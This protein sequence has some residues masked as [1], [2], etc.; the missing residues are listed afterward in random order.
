MVIAAVMKVAAL[1][2]IAFAA[3]HMGARDTAGNSA[4]QLAPQLVPVP[5]SLSPATSDVDPAEITA[6]HAHL[7]AILAAVHQQAA[8]NATA[9]QTI[10]EM[11]AVINAHT[12]FSAAFS[13]AQTSAG[14]SATQ[15]A[16]PQN[17]AAPSSTTPSLVSDNSASGSAPSLLQSRRDV[18]AL[19]PEDNADIF[20]MFPGMPL[21]ARIA[22]AQMLQEV[23]TTTLAF[24]AT[25][26]QGAHLVQ[27]LSDTDADF[28]KNEQVLSKNRA[29]ECAQLNAKGIASGDQQGI[30]ARAKAAL[31]APATSYSLARMVLAHDTHTATKDTQSSVPQD[32]DWDDLHGG[33]PNAVQQV[34][35]SNFSTGNST[36]M[37]RRRESKTSVENFFNPSSGAIGKDA[38]IEAEFVA[39]CMRAQA[40]L[41]KPD[42]WVPVGSDKVIPHYG[43]RSLLLQAVLAFL[44]FVAA[45]LLQSSRSRL[46]LNIGWMCVSLRQL[47]YHKH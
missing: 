41:P 13:Q 1:A 44:C 12:Q 28:Q 37:S 43:L 21:Y 16:A 2:A 40:N 10:P 4:P 8:Q 38:C 39:L 25:T 27:T 22:L 29:A 31:C 42:I 26:E 14:G 34:D 47:H 17:A 46:S 15:T 19:T 3:P 5:I 32:F 6:R 36:M 33:N 20:A 24:V 9:T 45:L 18:A 23:H 11:A 30:S 35:I 7:N